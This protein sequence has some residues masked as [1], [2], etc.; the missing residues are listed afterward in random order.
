MTDHILLETF[1]HLLSPLGN[2]PCRPRPPPDHAP[3]SKK[4]RL[5]TLIGQPLTNHDNLHRPSHRPSVRRSQ[6]R[7]PTASSTRHT[8]LVQPP[9]QSHLQPSQNQKTRERALLDHH[10]TQLLLVAPGSF[11]FC[12]AIPVFKKIEKGS[13]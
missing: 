10:F 6:S 2:P 1:P 13:C 8:P 12:I 5:A 7:R 11:P 4:P 9:L 3:S